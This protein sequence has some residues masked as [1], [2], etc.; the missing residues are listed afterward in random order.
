MPVVEL[1]QQIAQDLQD[2]SL[3]YEFNELNRR[4]SSLIAHESRPLDLLCVVNRGVPRPSDGQ[5]RLRR[6]PVSPSLT[7]GELSANRL[8]FAVPG[9]CIED[10]HFLIYFGECSG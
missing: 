9:L 7:V 6:T 10:N 3:N 1:I 4:R 8:Q 5:I 2:S